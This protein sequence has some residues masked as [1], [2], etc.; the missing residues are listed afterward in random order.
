[1]VKSIANIFTHDFVHF[2]KVDFFRKA[3]YVL[4]LFNALT[5]LPAANDLFAYYGLVGTRGWNTAIPIQRQGTFAFLNVLSHPLN[6]SN[7]WIMWVF[8]IGQIVFLVSGL[9]GWWPRMSSF[10]VFF[11]TANLFSKG[12]LAF[13]GGEVLVSFL[14]F[15]LMFIHQ[16]K[17]K[18]LFGEL[19]NVLNNAF[20]WILIG[21]I[22]ILYFFSAVYKLYDPDWI[23]GMA[24][25][26]I[27]QLDEYNSW[28]SSIFYS[29]PIIAKIATYTSLGYQ[30]FFPL[31]VWFKRVKIP[32]L[33]FGVLFHLIIALALGIFTFG[34]VMI[35]VYILF[36]DQNH[37]TKIKA[38]FKKS[39][40]DSA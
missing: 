25:Y 36:I 1:M 20:Y 15:Y 32:Y 8:V 7:P 28:M 10:M 22:C 18:G 14:L 9:K 38:K 2:E 35:L 24:I 27:A 37:L 33:L 26:Y 29:T 31:A 30:L 17:E 12:Y 21:Q 23:S 4:L 13:T 19:Q 16:P 39:T 6:A 40:T 3:L 34:V 11:F 5:L